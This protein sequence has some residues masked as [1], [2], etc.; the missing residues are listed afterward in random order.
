MEQLVDIRW[1]DAVDIGLVAALLWGGIAALR[2]S[3]A[4][5]AL[6]GLAS[7]G[8]VYLTAQRFELQLTSWMLQGFFAVFVI[9]LVVIFQEDLRRLFEQIAVWGLGRR[10]PASGSGT[11]DVLVRTAA[12]LSTTRIGALVVLPGREPLER[13]LDGGTL[14]DARVSEPLL[15]ALFDP[16]SPGHDGAILI[17]GDRVERCSVHL[18]L[19]DDRVGIGAG[20][21]RHAA[22][23]GLAERSDALCIAVSE[24]RGTVSVAYEG[25]LRVLSRPE[26]LGHE[27]R[28]FLERVAPPARS[29][30]GSLRQF[31][32]RWPEPLLAIAAAA[33]LWVVF[34]AGGSVVE[35]ERVAPVVVENLPEGFV[36]ERVEPPE[37][38]VL[39]E[40]TR[41]A[42][43]LGDGPHP[44]QVRVDA[45]LV[46][47]GRRTFP[48]TTAE[49]EHPQDLRIL[50]VRPARVRLSVRRAGE[51]ADDAPRS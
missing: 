8:L 36:L 30:A 38:M 11:M 39:L 48:I 5:L 31:A 19:S 50:D 4:T 18:P 27:L 43:V 9:V 44:V 21:T 23:L 22:A 40:G 29:T 32:R 37:V 25:A 16:N 45:L 46:Q 42:F 6:V 10:P 47:L 51:P 35:V 34:V 3:G 13:H 2:R 14:I 12:R 7:I 33:L 20:G 49:V 17:R 41:R 15:L 28:G 24:Q 1:Q 26:A